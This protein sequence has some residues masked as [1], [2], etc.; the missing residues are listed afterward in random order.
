MFIHPDD[1][2]INDPAAGQ[3]GPTLPVD[4]HFITKEFY[5]ELRIPWCRTPPASRT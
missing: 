4:G 2:Y 1:T 5:S 3:G